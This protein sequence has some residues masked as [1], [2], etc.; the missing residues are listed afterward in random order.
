MALDEDIEKIKE[1]NE[2]IEVLSKKLKEPSKIFEEGEINQAKIYIKSLRSELLKVDSDL[3]Y[4]AQSFKRSVQ[5][6]SKQNTFLNQGKKSLRGISDI[7]SR[8]L[9]Y[10]RD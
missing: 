2:E 5:E 3:N 7:S 8:E 10:F 4:I 1:L 9:N 6:L